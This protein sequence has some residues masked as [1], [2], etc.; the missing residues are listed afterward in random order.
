MSN[1]PIKFSQQADPQQIAWWLR[2]V[3]QHFEEGGYFFNILREDSRHLAQ[4]VEKIE[5]WVHPLG[6]LY[7]RPLCFYAGY[8]KVAWRVSA[9]RRGLWIWYLHQRYLSKVAA[10][11]ADERFQDLPPEF[12][13][14]S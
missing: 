2:E 4:I 7:N 10:K 14:V 1:D 13:E 5:L 6:D 3:P 12:W 9:L 11:V 8:D